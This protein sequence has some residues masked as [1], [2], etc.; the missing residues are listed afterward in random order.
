MDGEVHV[1]ELDMNAV[2]SRLAAGLEQHGY[3]VSQTGDNVWSITTEW[4]R[5][6]AYGE[7]GSS[8]YQLVSQCLTEI[9]A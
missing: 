6:A 1:Y 9:E 2:M 8:L 3:T 7:I 5:G 4:T